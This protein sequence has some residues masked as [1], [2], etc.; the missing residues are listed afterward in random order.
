MTVQF[1]LS[2]PGIAEFILIIA[3]ATAGAAPGGNYI[4]NSLRG[5]WLCL[6]IESNVPLLISE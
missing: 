3:R 1:F 5:T 2:L 6:I 4:S